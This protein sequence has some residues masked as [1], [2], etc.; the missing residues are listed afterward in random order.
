MKRLKI[1]LPQRE[2]GVTPN[3]VLGACLMD[4]IVPAE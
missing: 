2:G 4:L 3:Y 1:I